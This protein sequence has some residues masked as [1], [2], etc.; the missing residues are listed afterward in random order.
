MR[1]FVILA[2]FWVVLLLGGCGFSLGGADPNVETYYRAEIT[3]HTKMDWNIRLKVDDDSV[4]SGSLE[5]W[6][7]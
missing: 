6:I 2:S 7:S 4:H 3:S 5:L 1:L